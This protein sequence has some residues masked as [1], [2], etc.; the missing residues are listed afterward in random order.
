[1]GWGERGGDRNR[2]RARSGG[3]RVGLPLRPQGL[4][5]PRGQITLCPSPLSGAQ[6]TLCARISGISQEMPGV[7]SFGQWVLS[8]GGHSRQ[9]APWARLPQDCP[10]PTGY[11]DD[12]LGLSCFSSRL[13]VVG[14]W[15]AFVCPHSMWRK[16]LLK[17]GLLCSHTESRPRAL[18]SLS[19]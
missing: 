1:M 9:W 17:A 16:A 12:S 6:R 2:S 8:A 19:H 7:S 13:A 3:Q 15:S 5:S 11:S 4:C 18:F 10:A 14:V